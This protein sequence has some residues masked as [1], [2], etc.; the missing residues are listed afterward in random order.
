VAEFESTDDTGRHQL[1]FQAGNGSYPV[2]IGTTEYPLVG[3]DMYLSPGVPVV[4]PVPIPVGGQAQVLAQALFDNPFVGPS[5]NGGR[6]TNSWSH[7]LWSIGNPSLV[8]IAT[9]TNVAVLDGLASGSTQIQ[10]RFTDAA[11]GE[12]STVAPLDVF[13]VV[14]IAVEPATL[15]FPVGA[16]EPVRATATLANGSQTSAIDFA[17]SSSDD[18]IATVSGGSPLLGQSHVGNVTGW[19]SGT[20]TISAATVMGPPVSGSMQVSLVPPLRNR[21][22]FGFDQ[23]SS[24]IEVISID[25]SG[26][27]RFHAAMLAPYDDRFGPADSHASDEILVTGIQ[28]STFFSQIQRIGVTASVLPQFTSDSTTPDGDTIDVEA[29]R[30]RPDGAAYF[31]MSEGQH[32][33][34]R[35]A[36]NGSISAIGGPSGNAGFGPSAVAPAGS[37]VVYSAPWLFELTYRGKVVGIADLVARFDDT[38]SSNEPIAR[39][40]FLSPQLA[41]PGGNLWMLNATTG[42]MFRFVD[43]NGDGNHYFI[44]TTIVGGQTVMNAMDDPGERLLAGQLP[45]GFDT[46]RLD[47]ETGDMFASRIAGTSPQHVSVMRLRDLNSDG[48]VND[49][50]ERMLVFDA[51]APL[52]TNLVDVTLKYGSDGGGGG[53]VG[54]GIGPELALLMPAIG[55]LYGR[56]RRM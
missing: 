20:A 17:W 28:S 3:F 4:D 56:R 21:S 41:A 44:Q 18:A 31:A 27:G 23:Q 5:A 12:M 1:T 13:D 40:G 51:G 45:L 47:P 39:V 33:L 34:S 50:G 55:W 38:A 54:C 16:S 15:A 24:L 53:G 29:I 19:A 35:I 52:G 30:Y 25:K 48:D 49:S 9:A 43:L 37:N 26:I 46:L 22:L 10:A 2:T 42:E 6:G 7:F 11:L 36:P 8:A 32:L 14:A